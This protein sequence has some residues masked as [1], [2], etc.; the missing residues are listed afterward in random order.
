[1]ARYLARSCPRCNG[2]LGVVLREPGQRTA[3]SGEW[4]MHSLL[5]HGLDCYQRQRIIERQH[6]QGKSYL[7]STPFRQPA[8]Q[9]FFATQPGGGLNCQ[10]NVTKCQDKQRWRDY[11]FRINCLFSLPRR[12]RA[13]KGCMEEHNEKAR[14]SK[15]HHV[16]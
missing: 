5:S 3:A 7:E 6:S 16:R 8:Q 13:V 14:K 12:S 11:L 9:P 4:S 2:Y 1:M 15:K 10:L